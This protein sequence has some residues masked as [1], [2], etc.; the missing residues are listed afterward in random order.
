MTLS[1]LTARLALAGLLAGTSVAAIAPGA[2]LA[3]PA[4]GYADL[5]ETLTPGVVYIE[6]TRTT[7]AQMVPDAAPFDEFERRFGQPFPMPDMPPG[8]ER[9]PARGLGTGFVIGEDGRIVTNHHV[10][11]GAAEITVTLSDG[12]AFEAQILGADPLTDVA[13]IE[14]EAEGLT[15]PG[16]PTCLRSGAWMGV[17][18]EYTILHAAPER[19]P[20]P[21]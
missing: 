20:F 2:A 6:V 5:V 1:T 7:P 8:P 12:R 19:L 13:L 16:W 14:I 3:V 15:A 11:E 9:S 4:G 10:I 18:Y 17:G 21:S